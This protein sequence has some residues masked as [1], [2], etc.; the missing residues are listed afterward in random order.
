MNIQ[1]KETSAGARTDRCGAPPLPH[2]CANYVQTS[3][4][5]T[6]RFSFTRFTNVHI[7]ILCFDGDTVSPVALRVMGMLLKEVCTTGVL[8]TKLLKQTHLFA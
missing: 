5:L 3:P 1:D 7:L 4:Q 2:L 8:A 6:I